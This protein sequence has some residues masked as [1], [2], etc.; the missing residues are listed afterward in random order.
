MPESRIPLESL[1]SCLKFHVAY[2]ALTKCN[3]FAI[4]QDIYNEPIPHAFELVQRAVQ[5]GVT[6]GIYSN[7]ARVVGTVAHAR[8]IVP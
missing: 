4:R 1:R 3:R 2:A 7:D 6:L 5:A 8:I